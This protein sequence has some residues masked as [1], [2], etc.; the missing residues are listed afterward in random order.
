MTIKRTALLLACLLPG[1]ESA[2]GAPSRI[3][4]VPTL[5]SPLGSR[6]GAGVQSGVLGPAALQT[7]AATLSVTP[8]ITPAGLPAALKAPA[9]ALAAP[10]VVAAAAPQRPAPTVK[11][12]TAPTKALV[13]GAAPA[14][15]DAPDT[16]GKA[17]FDGINLKHDADESPVQG[18]AGTA[19]ASRLAPQDGRIV[20]RSYEGISKGEATFTRGRDLGTYVEK[21]GPGFH[22]AI[23]AIGRRPDPRWLDSGGGEGVAV[24]EYLDLAKARNWPAVKI[25]LL[26]YDTPARSEGLLEVLSGRYLE[27]IPDS[28][29]TKSDIITDLFGPLSYSG[30]PHLVLQKYLDRL[31]DG[32][33]AFIHLGAGDQAFGTTNQVVMADGRVVPFVDW[34]KTVPGLD[35][36][37]EV[38]HIVTPMREFDT[39]TAILT[40]RAGPDVRFPPLELIQYKEGM[41]PRMMFREAGH[42]G[43]ASAAL[44]ESA[45]AAARSHLAADARWGDAAMF[46]DS[47]RSGEFTSSILPAFSRLRAGAR[48]LD[49]SPRAGDVARG[50]EAGK[51]DFSKTGDFL[52]LAQKIMSWR[53]S[54]LDAKRY[55][56]APWADGPDGR[57]GLITD[58]HGGLQSDY[59]PSETLRRYLDAL[60]DDGEL[61]LSLGTEINGYGM[62]AQ[63]IMPDGSILTLR[64]WLM[65]R[66][67][68]IKAERTR[69]YAGRNV[70]ERTSVRI[71]IT[72]RKA[73]RGPDLE[74]FGLGAPDEDGVPVPV[75]RQR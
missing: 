75:Y 24:K 48:W 37:Y 62:R 60:A 43:Q 68:G 30:Q 8:S 44:V 46:L 71:S 51:F 65:S 25:T 66:I 15:A 2:L 16:S 47:F 3:P 54:R 50:M 61:H 35:F 56:H 64:E 74:V 73:A 17:L 53:A 42:T 59:R 22:A 23:D 41:P 4:E 72:D 45:R 33:K 20:K 52:G 36:E 57:A 40:R 29:I 58:F 11:P 38:R 6:T 1:A 67:P 63:V 13:P 69:A 5:E 70:G 28:E 14:R 32:G 9:P 19:G 31:K 26:A 55:A 21:L 39:G 10:V 18:V 12:A 34:L 49:S 27:K 7:Q